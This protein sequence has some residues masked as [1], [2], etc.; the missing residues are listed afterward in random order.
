MITTVG[1]KDLVLE[2]NKFVTGQSG[3]SEGIVA[4]EIALARKTVFANRQ[5]VPAGNHLGRKFAAIA[6]AKLILDSVVEV[7]H[8]HPLDTIS[9]TQ[10]ILVIGR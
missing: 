9:G 2:Q 6:A 4:C 1:V 5:I 3:L 7:P 8:V 10:S